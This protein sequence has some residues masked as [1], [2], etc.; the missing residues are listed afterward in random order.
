MSSPST[1]SSS[2]TTVVVQSTP[3]VSFGFMPVMPFGFGGYGYGYSSSG[4]II[5]LLLVVFMIW[6][7][8]S[9]F[10]NFSE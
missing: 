5:T 4:G 6:A 9:V 7:A 2:R 10:R 3:T 8:V 1:Y